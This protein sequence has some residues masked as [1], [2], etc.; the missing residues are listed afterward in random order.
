[1]AERLKRI[2][3]QITRYGLVIVL[4]WIGGMKFTAYEAEGMVVVKRAISEATA[5]PHP[6]GRAPAC[7]N[8]NKIVNDHIKF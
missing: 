2:G 7:A 8:I 6:E 1:M 4:L 5:T 3:T